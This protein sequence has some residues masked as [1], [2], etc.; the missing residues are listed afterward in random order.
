MFDS[1]PSTCHSPYYFFLKKII[2]VLVFDFLPVSDS[3]FQGLPLPH[4]PSY[5][6]HTSGTNSTNSSPLQS[7]VRIFWGGLDGASY[8][9]GAARMEADDSRLQFLHFQTKL[10]SP[11]E[12]EIS[13]CDFFFPVV[14]FVCEGSEVSEA[15]E[16]R[17]RMRMRMRIENR[18]KVGKGDMA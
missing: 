1:A 6:Q 7:K 11:R 8:A 5:G 18:E 10:A 3:G 12:P 14:N 9:V 15:R 16:V 4:P 2:I 13:S 17:M